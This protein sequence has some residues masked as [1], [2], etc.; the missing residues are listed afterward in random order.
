MKW[1][2]NKKSVATVNSKG[3]VTG[4][5]KGT[6]IITGKIDKKKYT[7]K[8]I[9][10][11]PSINKKSVI[12]NKGNTYQLKLS[13]TKQK[14]NWSSNNKSIANVNT[15]GKVTAK[16]I[17]K[18]VI[19]A[20]VNGVTYKCNITVKPKSAKATLLCFNKEY[21]YDLDKDGKKEKIIIKTTQSKG[22]RYNEYLEEYEEVINIKE[23][24][25]INDNEIKSI[26]FVDEYGDGI[27]KAYKA[28][29]VYIADMDISDKQME[30]FVI[31][32]GG[33]SQDY[34]DGENW[35]E[36][37]D[38]YT[39]KN[40]K[41][42]KVQNLISLFK[43]KYSF[44]TIHSLDNK[45]I[46]NIDNGDISVKICKKL[47][48]G[49]DFVHFKDC[50]SFVNGEFKVSTTKNYNLLEEVEDNI[51]NRYRCKGTCKIYSDI[52]EKK[53]VYTLKDKN[54]FYRMGLY[55]KNKKDIYLKIKNTKNKVGYVNTK[56]LKAYMDGT[57]HVGFE[58][59]ER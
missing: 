34:T 57:F 40:N 29:R 47:G 21:Q 42:K 28:F 9:V 53:V 23:T 44:Y 27:Q 10:E 55:I 3:V 11:T 22:T 18:V 41:V 37:I 38:Y 19:N 54:K 4:K 24:L 46:I 36:N 43:N 58:D 33:I 30:M 52:N 16:N 49:L 48:G 32:G 20:K 1:S 6:A 26:T 31:F 7:C 15:K 35:I 12:I 45:K 59:E 50:V 56:K 14:V 39:Y 8:V 2:T 5:K 25:Y 51:R 13:G 17:G